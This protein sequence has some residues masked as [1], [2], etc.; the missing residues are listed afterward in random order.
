MTMAGDRGKLV[1]LREIAELA[2]NAELA[3]LSAIRAE[4]ERPHARL[5]EIE[6][7]IRARVLLAASS[8]AF[9]PARLSGAEEA[10]SRWAD[11]ERRAA[12]R[13]LARIAER[14]EAQLARTRRAFG[15]KEAL[16]R[17]AERLAR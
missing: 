10:W 17:L 15:R 11:R 8:T 4:E 2:L 13:D 6:E 12:F 1:R 7:A 16:G 3:A 5:R 9:D 14:K